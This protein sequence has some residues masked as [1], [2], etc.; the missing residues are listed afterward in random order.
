MTDEV[1]FGFLGAGWIAHRALGP[2]VHAADGARL[3]AVA[4]RDATRAAQLRPAG[5]AYDDYRAVLDDP[6]VEVVYISL[7]NEVHRRW[8]LDALE[9][10]KHVL[11]EKPLGLDAAEVA[12]M[13]AAADR[14][15]RL[16]VEAFWYRWHPR[17]RRLEQLLRDGDLGTVRQVEAEFSFDGRTDPRMA[18]NFRM[19]PGRGGGA[20]YDVGCY[21]VSAAHLTLGSGL[22]VD[23]ARYDPGPTGVDLATT[24][25]LRATGDEPAPATGGG[26]AGGGPAGGGPAAFTDRRSGSAVVRCAIATPDRQ[27]LR[28]VGSQACVDFSTGE[29]FAN[30]HQPSALTIS[31]PHGSHTE[32]FAPVDPYRLM[33]E[34]VAAR[35]RGEE[36]FLVG[37]Q[38]SLDVATTLDA[39]R[40]AAVP[41]PSA[42]QHS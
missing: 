20:L 30:W 19:E 29:A 40:A 22:Q 33:V 42:A 10:G 1:R 39:I 13:T 3:Q 26:P 38:H 11:C 21:V 9:A 37:A 25:R 41:A 14:A 28:V 16:L 17:T 34:A 7:S 23:E 4:A 15:G 18:G 5:R 27:E 35:V 32:E 24:A 12:E 2:A 36:S 8:T 6:E 31:G